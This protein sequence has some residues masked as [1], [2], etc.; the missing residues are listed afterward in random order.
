MLFLIISIV[1]IFLFITILETIIAR[2]GI[3]N[4]FPSPK[5]EPVEYG[6]QGK[7]LIYLLM[8]D[9]TAAGQGAA[10]TDGIGVHTAIHLSKNYHVSFI[11]TGFSGATIKDVLF[12]QTSILKEVTPDIVLISAGANDA[13]RLRNFSQVKKDMETII[14]RIL[15]KNCDAKII[16]TGSPDVGSVKRLVPP[17]NWEVSWISNMLNKNAIKPLIKKYALTY[18]P[19]Y[20]ETG[21]IFRKDPSLLADD[22]FHPNAKGYAVWSSVL[23][24]A[25][26]NAEKNQHSHCE[27]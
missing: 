25:I 19:L 10:Y 14:E 15:A 3:T 11:N 24:K 16:L 21:P 5:R 7:K 26:D 22:K 2:N 27:R 6:K 9:S 12:D 18:A 4:D 23:N 20:E 17:L 13:T 1:I 8:G